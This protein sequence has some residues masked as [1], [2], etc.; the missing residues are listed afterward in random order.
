V[1]LLFLLLIAAIPLPSPLFRV[2]Y[3]TPLYDRSGSLLSVAIAEDDQWRFPPIEELPQRYRTALLRYE[4][5]RYPLHPGVDP[6]A[7]L[8]ALWQNVAAG[9]I[10]SG[11]STIS[12]Q[13]V[14]LLRMGTRR[15]LRQKVIEATLALKLELFH[16]KGEILRLY[17]SHAPFGGNT[18]GLGAAAWRYFGR[19]PA[20]LSWSEAAL[21]AVLPNSPSWIFPGSNQ[22]LLREKRD[23]LLHSLHRSG[24]IARDSLELA[25]AE[26]LPGEPLPFPRE[27][28]HLLTRHLSDGGGGTRLQSTLD[29]GL[30]SRAG[31]VVQRH[32]RR[33]RQS[34]I[35]NAAALILSLESGEA[36]AYVGNVRAESDRAAALHHSSVDVISAPRSPGSLLKPFLYA[37]ALDD[38]L[39]TPDQLIPD[40]P[41]FFEEFVPRNYSYEFNGAVPASQALIRSLNVPFVY[42]A[43]EY[44]YSRFYRQLGRMGLDFP[45]PAAHYGISLILGGAEASLWD[46]T[47]LFA[48]LGR[49]LSPSGSSA[50]PFFANRYR[51]SH[52]MPGGVP[53]ADAVQEPIPAQQAVSRGA[54]WSSFQAMKELIRPEAEESWRRFASARSIAWKT[55]T[56]MGF[57]DAWSVG[58]TPEYVIGVWI[59]NADGEGR[60]GINGLYA[61]APLLFDLFALLPGEERWFEAPRRELRQL[62]V[63]TVSG[64]EA[65]QYCPSTEFRQVPEGA[66]RGPRCPFHRLL[67]LDRTESRQVDSSVYPVSKMKRRVWFVL[68]PVQA[69]YYKHR[70]PEYRDP[71]PA[72]SAAAARMHFIYPSEQHAVLRLPRDFGGSG[73]AAVFRIAHRSPADELYWHLDGRYL[74]STRGFHEMEIAAAAGEHRLTV[75]DGSGESITRLFRVVPGEG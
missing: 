26:P 52:T 18:V 66:L 53:P 60:P 55:G 4:D 71:P 57:K 51:L 8:R 1:L 73:K 25:L 16:S 35:H 29:R 17:A 23:R 38:G 20:A 2:P 49:R 31:T 24:A 43:R 3:A 47:A 58:V 54:V 40:I 46:L 41:M 45:E 69:W 19:P 61:A 30:Q 63:C 14:R 44:D 5:R 74:G 36:L 27:A 48:G 7:V 39:I 68:P 65:N 9:K 64:M 72:R 59:G 22:T 6:L 70:H 50:S 21:L 11:A 12:M 34:G 15:N 56:S 33:L 28:P 37:L 42:L 75:V 13:T 62:S 67:H 32:H 10:V